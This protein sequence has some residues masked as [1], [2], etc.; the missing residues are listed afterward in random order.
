MHRAHIG[1][2]EH[3]RRRFRST[4]S[5]RA[6]GRQLSFDLTELLTH[7]TVRQ[8]SFDFMKKHASKFHDLPLK[9]M[10]NAAAGLDPENAT[11]TMPK[12]R[13]GNVGEGKIHLTQEMSEAIDARWHNLLSPFTDAKNYDE[14]RQNTLRELGR[15]FGEP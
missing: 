11:S 8:A 15:P 1:L 3:R 10:R 12:I 4:R 2:C 9:R 5:R 13:N 14:M 7:F 6:P